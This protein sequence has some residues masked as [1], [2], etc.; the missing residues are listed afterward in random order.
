MRPLSHGRVEMNMGSEATRIEGMKNAE[1]RFLRLVARIVLI[2]CV[3]PHGHASAQVLKKCTGGVTLKLNSGITTQGTLLLAEGKAAKAMPE[4]KAEWNGR[5]MA[6]WKEG[7]SDKAL[8]GLIG[9]DLEKA[10]GS[11]EWK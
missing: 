8:H 3:L 5:A 7:A 10:A 4:V 2:A 6:L 1:G 11:Y 9:V